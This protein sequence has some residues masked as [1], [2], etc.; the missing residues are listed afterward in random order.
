MASSQTLTSKTVKPSNINT[1][2]NGRHNA[3]L[4][5]VDFL[6][7]LELDEYIDVFQTEG[8]DRMDALFDINMDDLRDMKIKR[9]HAKLLLANIEQIKQKQNNLHSKK[10][11]FGGM[12]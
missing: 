7:T 11:R 3:W 5:V 1:V 6:K 12:Q 2:Q 9:G 8:F 4:A 10:V